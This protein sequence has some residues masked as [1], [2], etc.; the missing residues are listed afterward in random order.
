VPN[1]VAV[2]DG[3]HRFCIAM[4]NIEDYDALKNTTILADAGE[5]F[6]STETSGSQLWGTPLL[7]DNGAEPF[8]LTPE[9]VSHYR[10][11]F[12]RNAGVLDALM[13][14][15]PADMKDEVN[16]LIHLY[17][18]IMPIYLVFITSGYD[19]PFQCFMYSFPNKNT[20]YLGSSGEWCLASTF[21][22]KIDSLF[23]SI[24]GKA[25]GFD[26]LPIYWTNTLFSE[27]EGWVLLCIASDGQLVNNDTGEVINIPSG[28]LFAG[29]SMTQGYIR[30]FCTLEPKHQTITT[31]ERL[32]VK[33]DK[34]TFNTP[35]EAVNSVL[36]SDKEGYLTPERLEFK[37]DG[38]NNTVNMEYIEAPTMVEMTINY[39]IM[40]NSEEYPINITIEFTDLDGK[41]QGKHTFSGLDTY[42]VYTLSQNLV[43]EEGSE[44]TAVAKVY[45]NYNDSYMG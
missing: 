32:V 35:Y 24:G 42:K 31:S 39:D 33:N 25:L 2:S 22:K 7:A 12:D 40:I 11:I 8:E 9:E 13:K 27:A 23:S 18:N 34:V 44:I 6:S 45:S 30:P 19:V 10:N 14:E 37:A 4:Q 43:A 36:L 28:Q 3:T 17:K 26:N 15:L 1:G 5:G 16:S 21:S 29:N 38:Y 41:I 20:G